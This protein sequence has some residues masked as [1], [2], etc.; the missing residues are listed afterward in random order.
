MAVSLIPCV[1]TVGLLGWWSLALLPFCLA[2][3][4]VQARIAVANL[5]WAQGEG[6]IAFRRGAFWRYV[7]IARFTKMQ[8]V[9]VHESPFDRRTGMATL[10]VDTAGSS[11]TYRVRI[12]YLRRDV[13]DRASAELAAAAGTTEF[14]W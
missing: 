1:A 3:A 6:A 4:V 14:T 5:G 12:P 2:I 9:S 11:E 7:S 10:A 8:V 13:A